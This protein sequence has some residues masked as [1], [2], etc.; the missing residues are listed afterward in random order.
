MTRGLRHQLSCTVCNT[1]F[2]ACRSDTLYCGIACRQ[3]ASRQRR[4]PQQLPPAQNEPFIMGGIEQRQWRGTDIQRRSH[5]GYV[6]ATA[7]CS[8][9][10]KRWNHYVTN[11]R[12]SEYLQALSGSAG[13]PADRLV[14]SVVTGPNELRGT[15]VHPRLAVDLARWISP[16]FAVWMDGWF[17]E[18]LQRSAPQAQHGGYTLAPGITIKAK[19]MEDARIIWYDAVWRAVVKGTRAAQDLY[20]FAE[21]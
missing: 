19:S 2:S 8:A 6:N 14:A 11:D 4:Q 1:L 21:G 13:I 20:V 12:T 9:G 3:R 5:D 7:M 16:A 10:G 17:L 15:W 18:G